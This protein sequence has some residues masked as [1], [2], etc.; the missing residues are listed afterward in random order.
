[1]LN[2]TRRLPLLAGLVAFVLYACT[3]GSGVTA[4]SL[5]FTAKVAGW[6]ETPLVGQPLLWLLTL[7]V[8]WLPTAWV[9]LA[10]KLFTAATAALTLG[11][12]TRTIQLLPWDQSWETAGGLARALPALAACV[13][14]GLELAFW[15]E[16]T[17]ATGEMLDLLLLASALWLL[18]EYN[19]RRESRWLNAA[20]VIWGLGMAQNWVM[21]LTLPLFIGAVIWLQRL[22][23]F[24]AKFIL[25]LAGLGLAGFSIYA[26]LPMVNGLAPHSPWNLDQAWIASLRQTKNLGML[27]Y[28]QFWRAHRLLTVAMLI[29]FLVPTLPLLVRLRDEGTQNK[30]KV[31]RFQ[32]WLYRGLRVALLLACLWLAFDPAAGPQ[33]LVQ[34]QFGVGMSM[35]TF[36]YLNALGAGFLVGSLL[37]IAQT[38]VRRRHRSN[39]K[40]PWR[41]LAVPVAAVLLVLVAAGLLARNAPAIVRL[42]FHPLDQFGVTA[43]KSLPPGRGVMLGDFPQKLEVFQA[44]LARLHRTSDWLA[45]DTHALPSVDYRA[46]LER[47][48]PAGWLTDQNRHELTPVES[49]RLLTQVAQSNR[50]FYLHPSYG[51]FFEGFY[52][53][54]TGMIYEVKLR[55]KNPLELPPLPDSVTEANEKFWTSLWDQQLASLAAPAV[56][57]TAAWVARM[58]RYGLTPAPRYQDRLLADWYS[59]ALDGWAVALQKQGRL[60][61]ARQRFEQALR[62]NTNN[63]SARISLECNTNLQAGRGMGLADVTKVAAQLQNPNRINLILNSGGPFDEPTV[64]YL[65]GSVFFQGGMLLQAAEQF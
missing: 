18:L 54:P 9:T 15:Q 47:R 41:Q 28:F 55:G 38:D 3:M 40:I 35:L 45:V 8:H 50:L 30:S 11:L 21:L 43:A 10:L 6:D 61:E 42:N 58:K 48:Q 62:L 5:G 13:V 44:G 17:A 27:I 34:R 29:C 23:F 22:R 39:L 59:I 56:R 36:D 12:L 2:S 1:M 4:G 31:D 49:A 16:A 63:L 57:H 52:L 20:A 33:Q 25:L 14:G 37:L 24:R 53:T 7:P 32:L 46:G 64:T 26:L 65:L 19:L 60:P 51:H